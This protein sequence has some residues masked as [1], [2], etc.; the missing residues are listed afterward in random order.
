MHCG[1][2]IVGIH[3]Q[4]HEARFPACLIT[5]PTVD[6]A[7]QL[8]QLVQDL[9]ILQNL[10]HSFDATSRMSFPILPLWCLEVRH[11]DKLIV[12]LVSFARPN[13]GGCLAVGSIEVPFKGG[14]NC[15]LEIIS[16]FCSKNGP[17]L[18]ELVEIVDQPLG[19]CG[20][21]RVLASSLVSSFGL[22]EFVARANDVDLA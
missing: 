5:A 3:D 6:C 21:A 14:T 15:I 2:S 18:L 7:S 17:F 13:W 11:V 19:V 12:H 10:L 4:D 8:L 22:F 1:H 20:Q 16:L 9:L